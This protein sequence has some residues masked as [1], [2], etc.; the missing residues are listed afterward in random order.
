MHIGRIGDGETVTLLGKALWAMLVIAVMLKY[1]YF[2][3]LSYK[4]FC[5][6]AISKAVSPRVG[7]NPALN[8][9]EIEKKK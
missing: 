9:F 3:Y 2:E 7:A 4:H 5:L 1:N 6:T 8:S